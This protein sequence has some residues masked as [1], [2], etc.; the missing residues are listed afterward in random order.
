MEEMLYSFLYIFEIYS[1]LLTW[2]YLDFL[3]R[4]AQLTFK[5]C[6]C[7]HRTAL[8]RY[9]SVHSQNCEVLLRKLWPLFT[10]FQSLTSSWDQRIVDVTV[11]LDCCSWGKQYREH[12]LVAK[13]LVWAFVRSGF[14]FLAALPYFK[15]KN[16]DSRPW[17]CKWEINHWTIREF[18]YQ[19]FL[20]LSSLFVEVTRPFS[21][22]L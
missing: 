2:S 22:S 12:N 16:P 7:I 18:L 21:P 3:F 15:K 4:P 9:S 8:T 14:H 19:P 17:Q 10:F 20:I 5:S 11:H 6:A 13:V 1:P